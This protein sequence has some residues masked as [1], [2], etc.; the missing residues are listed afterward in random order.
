MACQ[1]QQLPVGAQTAQIYLPSSCTKHSTAVG[2]NTV[3]LQRLA[4]KLLVRRRFAIWKLLL[5]NIQK[6]NLPIDV[7][8]KCEDLHNKTNPASTE[9]Q[10]LNINF[11]PVLPAAG[12]KEARR[13]YLR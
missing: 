3:M 4:W 2:Q 7:S 5:P 11:G 13:K 8:A 1:C 12:L 10:K 9:F 6:K